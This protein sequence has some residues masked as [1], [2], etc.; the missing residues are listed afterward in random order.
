MASTSN[1]RS[2][3]CWGSANPLISSL[4]VTKPVESYKCI[5]MGHDG[6]VLNTRK[7]G[8]EDLPEKSFLFSRTD[9]FSLFFL[10][11]GSRQTFD[12]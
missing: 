1:L 8:F 6:S 5:V 3:L 4:V 9:K 10:V 2:E 7:P 12:A 11:D